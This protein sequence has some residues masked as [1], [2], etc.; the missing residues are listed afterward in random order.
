MHKVAAAS[1]FLVAAM[2]TVIVIAELLNEGSGAVIVTASLLIAAFTFAGH[3]ILTRPPTRPGGN[4][5]AD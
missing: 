1:S 5:S 2:W 4:D 3:R